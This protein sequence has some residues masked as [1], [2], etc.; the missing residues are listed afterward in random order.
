LHLISFVFVGSIP[1]STTKKSADYQRFFRLE[2]DGPA[3]HAAGRSQRGQ[4]SGYDVSQR[5]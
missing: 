5:L 3:P 1:L 2:T 4:R